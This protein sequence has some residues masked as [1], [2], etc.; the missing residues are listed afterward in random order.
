MSSIRSMLR[1]PSGRAD[2]H[3]KSMPQFVQLLAIITTLLSCSAALPRS[4]E[5][6]TG[7]EAWLRYSALDQRTAK[8]YEH[9]PARTM[10]L[11]DSLVLKSAQQELLRGA[12]QLLGKTLSASSVPD[13]AVVLGTLVQLHAL[14][15]TLYPHQELAGDGY[16]LKTFDIDQSKSLI[17]TGK[18]DRGVL[19]GVFALLRRLLK[20]KAS[21]TSMTSSI[22]AARIRWV[23][24]VG[25]SRRQHRARLWRPIDLLR[26]TA[27]FVTILLV[28]EVR[29]P[30]SFSRHQ[31]LHHQQ[32]QR[33]AASS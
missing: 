30:A 12:Q 2:F 29:S 17:I 14:K 20:A 31:R 7:A 6:E 15:I 18:T 8:S 10:L 16:W 28:P 1:V 9:F 5:A 4:V 11:G 33:G 13:N 24:S 21:R 3:W 32:R 22:L 19:Y 27:K 25:Q 26:R 23:E